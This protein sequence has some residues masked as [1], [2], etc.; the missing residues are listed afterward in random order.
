MSEMKRINQLHDRAWMIDIL[1]EVLGSLLTAVAIYCFAIPAGFPLTG[2][3]GLALILYRLAGLPI[4]WMTLL[5]NIPVALLCFKLIGRGFFLRSL[6]CMLLSSLAVDY[7]APL[8]P[9]YAGSRLIAAIC[10]GIIGGVG[11]AIIYLRNS[12]TGG[13]DFIVMAVKARFPHVRL[14]TAIFCADALIILVG[15][16]IFRDFDG[17]IYGLIVNYLY[18]IVADKLLYGMNAGKLAV[19]VTDFGK[20]VSAEI[21]RRCER[22]ATILP[23]SGAY[24]DLPRDVVLCACSNR[25]MVNVE[26]AVAEADP[27]AFTIILESNEVLGNGFHA[28]HVAESEQNN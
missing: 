18:A 11:Y 12:S 14:G 16:I 4:G 24:T 22:G 8:L 20:E 7:I 17:V 6:R 26:R 21:D 19:I 23:A 1:A 15:G 28:V 27:N 3:S 10:T 9:Q 5:L 2:F 25:E 13:S